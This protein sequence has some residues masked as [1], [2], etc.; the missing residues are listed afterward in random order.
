MEGGYVADWGARG[1]DAQGDIA[2]WGGPTKIGE[3]AVSNQVVGAQSYF[4]Y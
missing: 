1:R 3:P 4:C 2:W